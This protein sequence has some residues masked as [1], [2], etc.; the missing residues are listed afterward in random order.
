MSFCVN[1][2]RAPRRYNPK[3]RPRKHNSMKALIYADLQAT[4]GHERCFTDPAE[5]LQLARVK[6]FYRDLKR[7]YDSYKCDYLW[8][9]GDTTDDRSYLP[10]TAIDA[11]LE[12]LDP[13]PDNEFN[14][15]L[16]GNHEQYLRDTTKHIGRMF[17]RKFDVI[18]ST[19]VFEFDERTLL[20]CAAYPATY[21]ALNEW[22]GKMLYQYRCYERKILLGHFQVAGCSLNSGTALTGIDLALLRKCSLCL[23][24]HV[25]KPQ[26]LGPCHYVG[27]P[28]QQDFGEKGEEKRVG[29]LDLE[30]L[31]L[32]WVSLKGFP[33]YRVVRFQDWL[34]QVKSAEEHRYQVLL[35]NPKEAEAF[36]AHKLMNYATPI[37]DYRLTTEASK[38]ADLQRSW[39]KD[40]IMRRYLHSVPPGRRGI[41]SPTEVVLELGQMIVGV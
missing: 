38:E 30:T 13:F 39:T 33:E 1:D 28:F 11:V 34:Q 16:I 40:D 14:L 41:Q 2:G 19:E 8:D 6:R 3:E 35:S 12:G 29:I 5:P 21:P 22:I 36:Y 9:L 15:K 7:I 37:Y 23:L 20:I 17:D 27:S 4:D 10:M 25:H 26:S 31:K 18:A 32:T 24:G